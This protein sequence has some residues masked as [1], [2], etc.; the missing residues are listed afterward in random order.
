MDKIYHS[1]SHPAGFGGRD[2]LKIAARSSK[3]KTERFLLA[4][5]TYRR[6]K[7]NKQKFDRARIFVSSV[8]QQYQADLMDL[9]KFS[10]QNNGYK[11][12]L[13]VV[14]AFSRFTLAR[15]L[16][17]KTGPLVAE[18]LKDIFRQLQSDGKLGAS[19]LFA[20]DLG[21]EFWNTDAD[22]VYKQF[23]IGHFALRAPKKCSLAENS[24]R[25]LLDRIYK[26]MDHVGHNRWVDRLAEFVEA[27]NGRRN[28]KLGSVAPKDVNFTN[29]NMVFENLY[30]K[31]PQLSNKLPLL[32]GEKVQMALDRLPFHK[33][34]HGYF[35]DKVYVVKR[36]VNYDGIYRYTLMDP[37]DNVEISGTFYAE[38]LLPMKD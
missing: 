26:F 17:R 18:G 25:Y 15:P 29:Q 33:S 28:P 3:R 9:Q 22:E 23:N 5:R 20:T 31:S 10:R 16:K 13:V 27:K 6:F 38:E 34:F 11:Y 24:G 8:G 35:S 1:P 12:I 2:A 4:D 21:T 32:I 14:D 7:P 36:R 19:V 37:V 30:K